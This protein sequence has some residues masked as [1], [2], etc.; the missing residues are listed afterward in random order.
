MRTPAALLSGKPCD[1]S[2]ALPSSPHRN[3]QG[4]YVNK[5]ELYFGYHYPT[6]C[7]DLR[8]YL[9]LWSSAVYWRGSEGLDPVFKLPLL[10][11]ITLST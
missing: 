1:C 9:H 11:C 6:E 7:F 4:P 10:C 2:V 3:E 8:S 5:Q